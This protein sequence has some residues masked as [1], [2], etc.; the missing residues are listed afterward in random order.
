MF[1]DITQHDFIF[2]NRQPSL[3]MLISQYM[4]IIHSNLACFFLKREF[5]FNFL[6]IF[7]LDINQ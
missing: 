7:S 3:E 1:S 6:S 4:H 2:H 5:I